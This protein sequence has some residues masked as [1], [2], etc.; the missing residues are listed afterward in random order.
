MSLVRRTLV[1]AAGLLLTLG[2]ATT[3]LTT[4]NA[5]PVET[6]RTPDK[7]AYYVRVPSG[8]SVTPA[9]ALPEPTTSPAAAS[10][11]WYPGGSLVPCEPGYACAGVPWGSG[12]FVFKFYSYGTYRLSYWHGSGDLTNAQTGTAAVRTLD[13]NGV[14]IGCRDPHERAFPSWDPVWYIRLTSYGC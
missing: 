3:V 6:P 8:P 9:I 4:A 5:A 11:K 7:V 1:A 12:G 14:Q 10:R 2:T 13:Q